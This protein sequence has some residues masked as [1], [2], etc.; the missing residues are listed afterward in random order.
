MEKRNWGF[1]EN[2]KMDDR[3]R[4]KTIFSLRKIYGNIKHVAKELGGTCF[5]FFRCFYEV[6]TYLANVMKLR[7]EVLSTCW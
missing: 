4:G 6:D 5:T 1:K 2:F 7:E 3:N